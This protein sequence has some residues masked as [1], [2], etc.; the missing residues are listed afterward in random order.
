[1]TLYERIEQLRKSKGLSQGKLERELGF[2]NGSVSKWKNSTPTLER[3]QKIADYFNVTVDYL[4]TGECESELNTTL[5]SRDQKEIS[6]ILSNTEKL[7][8]QDGLM[9]DGNPATQEEIDSIISAMKIGMELA[10]KKNKE[11]YTPK[12]YK[13]DW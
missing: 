5:T 10:K 11:K 4:T 7:L 2:S 1:M 12:K 9:F 3:L 13:K 6:S 8:R